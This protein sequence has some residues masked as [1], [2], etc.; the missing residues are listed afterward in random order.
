MN[1][2]GLKSLL[3]RLFV[4]SCLFIAVTGVLGPWIIST[5]LLYGFSFFIYANMGKMLLFSVVAFVILTRKKYKD[6]PVFPY[7]RSNIFFVVVAVILM[8]LFYIAGQR[9]LLEPS[10]FSNL[11]LFMVAHALI[12]A[13]PVFLAVGVFGLAFMRYFVHRFKQELLVCLVMSVVFYFAIFQ[14]WK[15]WPYFSGVVLKSVS[16]L[17]SLHVSPVREIG[18]LT[19][20]V[21][22]FAVRVEQSCSGL[23][24]IFL[25]SAL[26]SLI[27]LVEWQQFRKLRVLLI[28]FPA[29]LGLFLVNILRVYVLILVGVYISPQLAMRLFHTYLGMVFFMVYFY[30]FW[31]Y[32]MKWLKK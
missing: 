28:F 13:I 11:W 7:R 25:F 31:M 30:F 8:G 32:A 27:V 26:Y 4:F 2:T 12:I 15:L 5:R 14:V 19:L 1:T 21:D 17:L 6:I 16:F 29:L 10:A 20:F 24:S 9:L 22:D 18:P 3:V 23:D